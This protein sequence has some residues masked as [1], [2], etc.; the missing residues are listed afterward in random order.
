MPEV[1]DEETGEVLNPGTVGTLES[2]AATA[3]LVVIGSA[4]FLNDI[5]FDMSAA[6]SGDR[7]LNSLQFAENLVDWSVED[8]DLLSIRSSGISSRPLAPLT[9]RGQAIWESVNYV[10]ALLAL[11]GLGW[12]WHVRRRNEQAMEIVKPSPSA[13]D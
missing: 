1:I 7:Y 12:T 4:E 6:L 2:S 13:A 8:L 9:E 10:V 11:V 3:R 5:V